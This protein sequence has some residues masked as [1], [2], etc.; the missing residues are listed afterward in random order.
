MRVAIDNV[1]RM[2]IPKSLRAELG[3]NGAAEVEVVS[4][5]GHLELSV[6]EVPAHLE[7]RDGFPVIVPETPMPA[8]T[9]EDVRRTLER[10]RR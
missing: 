9:A 7:L 4:A 6:P 1:G 2:V 5:D 10:V 3:I 8:M